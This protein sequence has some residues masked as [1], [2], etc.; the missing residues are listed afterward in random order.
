MQLRWCLALLGMLGG[1]C[2]AGEVEY[3][4]G[5][6][7]FAKVWQVFYVEADHESEI[8][9][10]L[11]AAGAAM[12]PAIVEAVAHRDMKRRR[13]ALGALGFIQDRRALPVLERILKN[14]GESVYCR[15]DALHAIYQ[16]DRALGTR[17]ARQFARDDPYLTRLATDINKRAAW[18]LAPTDD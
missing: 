18:L 8:D 10:P 5:G 3:R 2:M 6:P 14:Q 12:T 16:I 17:Y 4:T 7:R 15:G 9:D 13:Y 1:A 11:I